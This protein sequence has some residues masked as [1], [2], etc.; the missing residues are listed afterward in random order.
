M[1]RLA[2][3]VLIVSLCNAFAVAQPDRE[4]QEGPGKERMVEKVEAMRV[5]FLT[6]KLDLTT[7]ES[8]KFWPLYNEYSKYRKELRKD[9]MDSRR[10]QRRNELTEEESQKALEEQFNIQEKEL[11]LKKNYYEKFKAVLPPQKLAKLE[12]AENEFNIEV[13]RKLKEHRNKRMGGGMRD[14]MRK[15]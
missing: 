2:Y 3:I 15:N 6:S 5:A 4:F 11:T 7:E 9:M 13:I 12:P 14:R 10:D 1:I 8:E